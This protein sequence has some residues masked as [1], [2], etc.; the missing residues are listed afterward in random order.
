[1]TKTM[2]SVPPSDGAPDGMLIVLITEDPVVTEL[3]GLALAENPGVGLA[4]SV[5]ARDTSELPSLLDEAQGVLLLDLGSGGGER[6]LLE[7]LGRASTPVVVLVARGGEE[8]AWDALERGAAG[9]LIRDDMSALDLVQVLEQA[10]FRRRLERERQDR[11]LW[12]EAI[13][14]GISD[15]VAVV[16][17]DRRIVYESPS[18]ERVLGYRP[19]EREGDSVWDL[20]HPDDIAATRPL[21]EAT[22][23]KPGALTTVELRMR[24]KDGRWLNVEV[25]ARNAMD[26]PVVRG[27]VVTLHDVT[28]RKRGEEELRGAESRFRALVEQSL[29]GIYI[30]DHEGKLAYINP[31]WCQIM[32]Y[33]AGAIVGT[34]AADLVDEADRAGFAERVRARLAGE[35]EGERYGL[36]LRSREGRT[37]VADVF[38]RRVELEGR[39]AI[40]GVL[41]D[42]TERRMLEEEFLHAQK[43]EVVGRLASGIAHDFN[44]LL[45][46]IGA[47]AELIG[48]ALYEHEDVLEDVEAIHESVERG[49]ALAQRLL[50]FGRKDPRNTATV[51][52][53]EWLEGY[54]SLLER[55]VPNTIAVTMQLGAGAAAVAVDLGQLEQVILNL[56]I[57]AQ[58]AMPH[59]GELGIETTVDRTQAEL[60][61]AALKGDDADGSWLYLR[62]SDTGD[63]IDADTLPRIFQPFFTTKAEGRGTGLGLATVEDFVNANGGAIVADSVPGSGTAFSIRLPRVVLE[64]NR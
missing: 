38:G 31:T 9:V 49:R 21:F 62:A 22:L 27:L 19:E 55:V 1:M 13:V 16:G 25:R 34:S 14:E 60:W 29:V 36:R 12:L 35:R 45:Q 47:S 43:M 2:D 42:L 56:V 44:N 57:N 30:I 5:A 20:I 48:Q 23:A 3:V 53:D 18:M 11:E 26:S 46:A 28:D 7:H 39:P 8:H 59:G 6:A 50:S 54:R 61:S 41:Q 15:V 24:H 33:E 37:V 17:P 52:V 58:D 51:V 4:A 63:G 32:G 10:Q 64:T 40:V